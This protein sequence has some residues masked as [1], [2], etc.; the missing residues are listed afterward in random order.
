MLP[1]K[2]PLQ[3]MNYNIG[4]PQLFRKTGA[5]AN[6]IKTKIGIPPYAHWKFSQFNVNTWRGIGRGI[7]AAWSRML[8]DFKFGRQSGTALRKVETQVRR[9]KKLADGFMKDMDRQMYKLAGVGFSDIA[10]QTVT[11]QRALR[12]WDTVIKYMRGDVKIDSLPKVLRTNC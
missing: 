3:K 4:I 6:K 11:A 10:M 8:S 2:H 9:I 1:K 12:H 5:L 7:E